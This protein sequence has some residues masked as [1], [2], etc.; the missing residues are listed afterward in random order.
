MDPCS[1]FA[2]E[3]S[4]DS[5]ATGRSLRHSTRVTYE[6]L[7]S[8]TRFTYIFER[9]TGR[10]FH[11]SGWSDHPNSFHL[12]SITRDH[13][14]IFRYT[15]NSW[16]EKMKLSAK[17]KLIIPIMYAFLDKSHGTNRFDPEIPFETERKKERLSSP[18]PLFK[19]SYRANPFRYSREMWT[20]LC[21][22]HARNARDSIGRFQESIFAGDK[23]TRVEEKGM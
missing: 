2:N 10:R 8:V 3:N 20:H 9:L 1:L 5:P 18:L 15:H 17:R 4:F 12:I 13:S 6:S 22:L 7:T 16:R 19:F 11:S 23:I 21:S 14:T